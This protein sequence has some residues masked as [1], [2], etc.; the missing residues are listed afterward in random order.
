VVR[1][2]C[3]S[4][5]MTKASR[6]D[7]KTKTPDTFVSAIEVLHNHHPESIRLN[8]IDCPEK[9]QAFGL[10]AE[11]VASDLVFR[12][13]VTLQTHGLDEY[14]R[15]IGDVI[16][17]DG[18]TSIRNSSGGASAGGIVA[19][20]LGIRCWKGWRRKHE[21]PRKACG[22]IRSRCRR[23]SGGRGSKHIGGRTA[24]GIPVP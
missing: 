20:R 15:T 21:R 6:L 3:Q 7:S 13:E 10:L 23:G 12:K 14:G 9:G 17:P 8:G 2:T 18:I 11:H 22:P 4:R 16:L 24:G 5:L 19:T 1:D